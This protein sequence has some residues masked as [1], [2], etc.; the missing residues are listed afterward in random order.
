MSEQT[1]RCQMCGEVK[2]VEEFH[3]ERRCSDGRRGQCKACRWA[4]AQTP[5]EKA[6]LRK[7]RA[8]YRRTEHG[9]ARMLVG[10]RK[11]RSTENGRMIGQKRSRKYGALHPE[12]LYAGKAVAR[13]VRAGQLPKPSTL[14]CVCCGQVAANYHHHIGYRGED[15][16]K[17]IPLCPRCHQSAETPVTES[18]A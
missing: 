7:A 10:C 12:R 14:F 5:Q 11:Y 13:A 15:W 2:D 17:V 16:Y 6:V 18:R 4:G 8:K 9:R 3:R 1:K